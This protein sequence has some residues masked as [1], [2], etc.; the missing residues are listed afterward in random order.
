MADDRLRADEFVTVKDIE[1]AG[2]SHQGTFPVLARYHL[3][4]EQVQ[5]IQNLLQLHRGLAVFNIDDEAI[6]GVGKAG[7]IELFQGKVL[8]P[9]ADDCTQVGRRLDSSQWFL[10]F[11]DR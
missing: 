1:A 3:Q 6:A 10:I 7:E 11:T 9:I 4:P 2:A 5:Q 8:P